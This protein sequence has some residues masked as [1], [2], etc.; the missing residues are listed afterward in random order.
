MG[1][2]VL[3]SDSLRRTLS[4]TALKIFP[5]VY[6]SFS[7]YAAF[8]VRVKASTAASSVSESGSD[9]EKTYV[10]PPGEM[11]MKNIVTGEISQCVQN[12]ETSLLPNFE[13][14][15]PSYLFDTRF[16]QCDTAYIRIHE[17]SIH[18]QID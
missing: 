12:V 6:L 2:E 7:R 15:T 10:P 13:R 16:A 17:E 11:R 3:G 5:N 9:L 14:H 18:L 8:C 4:W 1:F